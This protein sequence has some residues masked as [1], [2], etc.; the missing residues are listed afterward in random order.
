MTTC[1]MTWRGALA[2][3]ALSALALLPSAAGAQTKEVQEDLERQLQR[4]RV[5]LKSADTAQ[6][7]AE[8]EKA[9]AELAK[10]KAEMEHRLAMIKSLE[11]KLAEVK[12]GEA[13]KGR[14]VL[15]PEDAKKAPGEVVII[16]RKVGDRWEVVQP[17]AK[18][19]EAK[20]PEA[21][22]YRVEEKEGVLRV[23]P[24]QPG[25]GPA[26][27]E[28]PRGIG[29]APVP[30]PETRPPMVP[31]GRGAGPAP[32]SRLDNLEHQLKRV[33]DELEAL[34][35]EM[36]SQPRSGGGIKPGVEPRDTPPADPKRK[37][38][39]ENKPTPAPKD[40]DESGLQRR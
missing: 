19:P 10:L 13:L 11:A 39:P 29:V 8:L 6:A 32:E 18:K 14:L 25:K 37:P 5:E 9:R 31:M 24:V 7:Q 38:A 26:A 15:N 1:V 34:R 3:L 17:P 16:L 35:K 20:Q 4:L 28:L 23:V 33:M 2:A 27:P 21:R 30:V 12:G 36:R 40:E 22:A